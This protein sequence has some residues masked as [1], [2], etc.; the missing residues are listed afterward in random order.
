M[1]DTLLKKLPKKKNKSIV[2][3]AQKLSIRKQILINIRKYVKKGKQIKVIMW[4]K[5][6]KGYKNSY[7]NKIKIRTLSNQLN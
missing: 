5:C 3:I 6:L 4:L 1:A 7:S 2:V